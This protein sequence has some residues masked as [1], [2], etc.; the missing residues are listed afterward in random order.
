MSEP[1]GMHDMTGWREVSCYEADVIRR[2]DLSPASSCTDP[3][4]NYGSPVVFTEWWWVGRNEIPVLRDY[5]RPDD[6][7][8]HYIATGA[9]AAREDEGDE[10]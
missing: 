3:D 7:C 2:S 10:R 6:A 9:E 4:G 8:M 1:R 5:R